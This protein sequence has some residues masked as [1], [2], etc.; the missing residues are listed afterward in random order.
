MAICSTAAPA[1]GKTFSAASAVPDIPRGKAS[2]TCPYIGTYHPAKKPKMKC[3]TTYIHCS[4]I[5]PADS[6][7]APQQRVKQAVPISS[8]FLRDLST[9]SEMNPA[10]GQPAI[11]PRPTKV[12]EKP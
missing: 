7:M 8:T 1:K 9:L 10:A 11:I 6:H 2:L 3:S 12:R 5:A 4:R